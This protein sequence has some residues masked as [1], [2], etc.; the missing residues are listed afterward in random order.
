M[1]LIL[2][3]LRGSGKTTAG[4]AAADLLS[5]P[6]IDLD[7]VTQAVCGMTAKTCF[8]T[9][10]E[11]AWRAAESTALDRTLAST[12]PSVIALGGGTPTAPGALE[13]LETERDAGRAR[14]ILLRAP[15]ND[16]VARIADDSG[17]PPLTAL[18]PLDEMTAM[19]KAR[20]PM[21]ARL[22]TATIDTSDRSIE[23]VAEAVVGQ[24]ASD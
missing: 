7:D 24:L 5:R 10:G 15:T 19:E 20:G 23:Q 6:F 8:E 21:L 14:I 22:A 3:G 4:R 2:I 12:D 16:L 13:R 9:A 1:H 11:A 17:R 18:D